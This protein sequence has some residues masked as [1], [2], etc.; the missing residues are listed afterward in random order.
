MGA[1]SLGCLGPN[2]D[3]Y[4]IGNAGW[5]RF[6]AGDAQPSAPRIVP[7]FRSKL[8]KPKK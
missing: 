1:P 6:S 2:G 7:V 5:T 4:F 8:T 3:F